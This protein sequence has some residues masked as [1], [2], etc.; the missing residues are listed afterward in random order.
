MNYIL[1][2]IAAMFFG[3]SILY[4]VR[5]IFVYRKIDK[6][7]Y[8]SATALASTLYALSQLFLSMPVPDQTVLIIHRIKLITSLF[9]V[10]FLILVTY[11]LFGK[12]KTLVRWFLAGIALV[13]MTIPF[14]IFISMPVHHLAIRKFDIVFNYRFGTT[15]ISYSL[16]SLVVLTA[17]ISVII[18]GIRTRE[19]SFR[20]KII[21]TFIFLPVIISAIND[22]AVAH[23]LI[24]NIMLTEYAIFFTFIMIFSIM[25]SEEQAN[26]I[27]LRNINKILKMNVEER[28]RDLAEQVNQSEKLNRE[29]VRINDEI[30]KVNETMKMDMKMARNV[31]SA[32]LPSVPKDLKKWEIAL[33]FKPMSEVSGDFYDFYVRDDELDGIG[34]FDVSGHGVASSLVT[35]Q[36]K[37]I[38]YKNFRENRNLPLGEVASRINNELIAELGDSDH[39]ISGVLI[40]FTDD[41]HLEYVNAGHSDILARDPLGAV[42]VACGGTQ[43]KGSYLAV[44]VINTP[45]ES[46]RLEFE[47]GTTFLLYS[48]ALIETMDSKH[49]MFGWERL[50]REFY[51]MPATLSVEEQA[52]YLVNSLERFCGK[53]HFDDDLTIIIARKKPI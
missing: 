2:A 31:Q 51:S 11:E 52:G 18:D 36:A 8:F 4:A 48:D 23:G 37:S 15:G 7:I 38:I 53:S 49:R 29:L 32:F 16:M 6:N 1:T 34:L 42:Y 33:Y 19:M 13:A 41:R 17:M 50:A 9:D 40:R 20:N 25:Y 28:T 24:D 22:Y 39:F 30:K 5:G 21:F 43:F 3:F 46:C 45:Y 10:L 44:K 27:Y 12:K 47:P 14:D 35:L 26:Y